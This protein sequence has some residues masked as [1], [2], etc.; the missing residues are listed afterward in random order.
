MGTAI[1]VFDVGIGLSKPFRDRMPL[2]MSELKFTFRNGIDSIDMMKKI[3]LALSLVSSI[4]SAEG[5][6][7]PLSLGFGAGPTIGAGFVG[8]YEWERWGVQGAL[9]PFYTPDS[10]TIIEGVT[11]IYTL[12]RN[13][14]G[15]FYLSMGAVGWHRMSVNYDFPV[16]EGKVDENG[17]PLSVPNNPT[18]TRPWTNGFAGG[19][20]FGMRFN[21]WGNYVFSFDLPAAVVFEVKGGV[22]KF[23]SFRPWPNL[24]LLYNF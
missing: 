16:V 7:R 22:V 21:F 23:D 4:A 20:G 13:P 3:F 8:R 18:I 5:I 6:D 2:H 9:L 10:A 24:V 19:P 1:N 17:N 14:R 15:S 11:G 12:D